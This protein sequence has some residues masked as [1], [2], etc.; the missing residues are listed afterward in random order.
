MALNSVN[1]ALNSVK[2]ASS[3]VK[4]VAHHGSWEGIV[5]ETIVERGLK[6]G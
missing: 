3:S 2:M 5:V 1:M 4:M 6:G